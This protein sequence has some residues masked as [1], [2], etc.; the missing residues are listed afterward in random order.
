[1]KNVTKYSFALA[2]ILATSLM[3][4][5]QSDSGSKTDEEISGW[6]TIETSQPAEVTVESAALFFN[7]ASSDKAVQRAG[8]KKTVAFKKF[9]DSLNF[10]KLS[11]SGKT[12][13]SAPGEY[14]HE[15]VEE[16]SESGTLTFKYTVDTNT[17]TMQML[18]IYDN[19]H[20]IDATDIDACG[21]IDITN[22]NGSWYCDVG[23]DPATGLFN[24]FKCTAKTDM[25]VEGGMFYEGSY[26][27]IWDAGNE[28]ESYHYDIVGKNSEGE[29]FALLDANETIWEDT[30][31]EYSNTISGR[32]YFND[33]KEYMTVDPV[34]N[35][36]DNHRIE[37][38]C[39]DTVYSGT[40]YLRGKDDALVEY[41]ITSENTLQISIDSD[42]DG[43]WDIVET[44]LLN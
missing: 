33:L 34:L 43:I 44:K 13:Q 37:G 31:Y 22:Q 42:N 7:V 10:D 38:L 18:Q 24:S 12:V 28:M 21:N 5:C 29:K 6:D 41:N 26:F 30:V 14:E 32:L 1:M 3:T 20:D 11:I 23:F 2:A 8:E 17:S 9:V 27:A 15:V 19:Y 16:G 36:T 4:G 35:P 25:S 39:N 40:L